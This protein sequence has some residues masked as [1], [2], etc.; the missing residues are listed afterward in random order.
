MAMDVVSLLT[1]LFAGIIAAVELYVR[2]IRPNKEKQKQEHQNKLHSIKSS[3]E[4]LES[5]KTL[6]NQDVEG[7]FGKLADFDFE[8]RQTELAWIKNAKFPTVYQDLKDYHF[9]TEFYSELL[10]AS[11]ETIRCQTHYLLKTNLFQTVEAF[12]KDYP[13]PL[14]DILVKYLT[15]PLLI[16]DEVTF[17]SLKIKDPEASA[18]LEEHLHEREN[19]NRFFKYFNQSLISH[20]ILRKFREIQE[21]LI[22]ETVRIENSISNEIQSLQVELSEQ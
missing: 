1:V 9:K 13:R 20:R 22:R 14:V 3:I 11:K 5:L 19:I 8:R 18:R 17:E 21:D 6:V 2:I 16:G 4:H 12:E 7:Y 10:F 15:I